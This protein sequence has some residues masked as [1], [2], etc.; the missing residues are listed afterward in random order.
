MV[1]ELLLK[2][3]EEVMLRQ[4]LAYDCCPAKTFHVRRRELVV[5]QMPRYTGGFNH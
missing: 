1:C 5:A 2:M 3:K 4:T